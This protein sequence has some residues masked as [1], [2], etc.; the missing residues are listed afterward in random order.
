MNMVKSWAD[1]LNVRPER[2]E[3]LDNFLKKLVDD[4]QHSFIGF[5]A[6]R[7]GQV[8]FSGH[9]GV[10]KPG[11]GPLLPDAIYPMQSITKIIT[12]TCAAILQEEGLLDFYD[13]VSKHFQEFS[14]DGKDGVEIWQMFCHTSG[15][16][17]DAIWKHWN[18]IHGDI[19]DEDVGKEAY[20]QTKLG[21]PLAATPGSRFIYSN[22]NYEV[23]AELVERTSGMTFPEF[24]EEQIFKPLGMVDSHFILPPKKRERYVLRRETAKGGKWMNG[25]GMMNSTHPAGGWKATHQDAAIFG[26]MWL[27]MGTLNGARIL[28]PASVKT[29]TRD[30]NTHLP[31]GAWKGRYLGCNWGL[32]WDIK[33]DKID[34]HG[35]IRSGRSYNH[36]GFGGATLLIEPDADLVI[37]CYFVEE[38]EDS[39]G[40]YGP[41]FNIIYSALD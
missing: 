32:G 12:A 15:I 38:Q 5:H 34:D 9:Y 31:P 2:L 16:D 7:R 33:G 19:S 25:D 3:Y 10:Q 1:E 8:I 40:D 36:S 41:A 26:Q 22:F 24:S 6:L 21:A 23:I 35:F 4:D 20:W 37:S 13:L 11:G 29:M 14:G 17:D 28:S 30:L 18:E 27:N 39:Y